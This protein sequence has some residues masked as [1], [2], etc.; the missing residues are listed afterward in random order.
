[1]LGRDVSLVSIRLDILLMS[2]A[3]LISLTPILF[4]PP[5]LQTSNSLDSTPLKLMPTNTNH[6]LA[7]LCTQCW[8]LILTLHMRWVSLVSS[9]LI[10]GRNILKPSIVFLGISM[11]P[12]ITRSST[13][14]ILM[15]TTSLPI[16][17]L[18]GPVILM[19]I[20]PFLAMCSRSPALLLLGVPRNSP[21]LHYR[22]L[23]GSIW[24]FHMLPKR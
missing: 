4:P 9:Q 21:P 20:D 13:M 16:A 18:T 10:L 22:V 12:R 15:K 17:T 11:L 3:V 8:E 6:T 23:K 19:I 7:L 1:M 2:S 24:H 5:F 14:V